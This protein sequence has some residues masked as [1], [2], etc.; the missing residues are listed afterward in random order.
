[1]TSS[2]IDNIVIFKKHLG[3]NLEIDQSYV[4]LTMK[5]DNMLSF[6]FKVPEDLKNEVMEYF[7]R[8]KMFEPIK[9]DIGNTGDISAQFKGISPVTK[10]S[11]N[12][13]DYFFVSVLLQETGKVPPSDE[14]M[15]ETC[16]NC[17]FH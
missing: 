6:N 16:S 10:S 1:M 5:E 14:E 4:G 7:E 8:F 12:G 11:D 2:N 17:G 3:L 9:V 15:C 13:T